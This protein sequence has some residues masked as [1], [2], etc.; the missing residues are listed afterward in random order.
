[1]RPP[2]RVRSDTKN[3]AKGRQ[4]AG[5]SN[6]SENLGALTATDRRRENR[7]METSHDQGAEAVTDPDVNVVAIGAL[8]AAGLSPDQAARAL[9]LAQGQAT[10]DL[11][12]FLAAI[13]V[14]AHCAEAQAGSTTE[15]RAGVMSG[16]LLEAAHRAI[17][18]GRSGGVSDDQITAY[19]AGLFGEFLSAAAKEK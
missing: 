9:A 2:T 17:A 11:A 7:H 15:A 14:L 4:A 3:G 8:L 10:P 5:H 1:M 13:G 18:L 19:A 12:P 6:F 16:L